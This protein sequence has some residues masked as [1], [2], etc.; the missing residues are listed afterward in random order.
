MRDNY[1][2]ITGAGAG[3]GKSFAHE[4]A[5]KGFNL[6]LV[7][8][9]AHELDEVEK[10]LHTKFSKLYIEK[11][12]IDLSEKDAEEKIVA[13]IVAKHIKLKGLINNVGMGYTDHFTKRD[14]NFYALMLQLNVNLTY[15]LIHECLKYRLLEKNS[16]ILNVASM[17]ALFSLPYKSLYA[18]SKAFVLHFSRA[19]YAELRPQG[20]HVACVC[21]GPMPTNPEIM[22]RIKKIGWRSKLTSISSTESVARYALRKTMAGSHLIFVSFSDKLNFVLSRILPYKLQ[23]LILATLTNKPEE[24]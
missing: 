5:T 16:F 18:A 2:L 7:S 21:P 12:A 17:A 10:E 22:E 3:L 13:E 1:I 14:K 15:R 20:I 4:C 23:P 24:E 19:M 8:K 6:V 11:I 9:F